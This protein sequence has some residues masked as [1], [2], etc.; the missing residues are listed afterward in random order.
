MKQVKECEQKKTL[1]ILTA[2]LNE[3]RPDVKLG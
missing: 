2:S 3:K 1:A